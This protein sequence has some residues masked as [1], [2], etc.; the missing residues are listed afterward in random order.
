M[1]KLTDMLASAKLR[2]V[3]LTWAILV[4]I[5]ACYYVMFVLASLPVHAEWYAS[6]Y[7]YQ[8]IVFSVMR[9]PLWL[10]LLCAYGVFR[11]SYKTKQTRKAKDN[12]SKKFH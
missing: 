8:L 11:L 6:S 4:A 2:L 3:L 1:T 12:E 9:L 10:V 7:S 5:H